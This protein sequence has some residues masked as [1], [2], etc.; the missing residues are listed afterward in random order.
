MPTLIILLVIFGPIYLSALYIKGCRAFQVPAGQTRRQ[1]IHAFELEFIKAVFKGRIEETASQQPEFISWLVLTLKMVMAGFI[2]AGALIIHTFI[3]AI[4]T[5]KQEIWLAAFVFLAIGLGWGIAAR[6][7][8]RR[9]RKGKSLNAIGNLF[10]MFCFFGILAW[11]A[12]H[13]K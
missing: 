10:L 8:R 11:L 6:V 4:L 2:L 5:L 13:V 1:A 3:Q 12:I 9:G 7:Y